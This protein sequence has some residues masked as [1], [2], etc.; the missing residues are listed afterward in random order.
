MPV[1]SKSKSHRRLRSSTRGRTALPR[2]GAGYNFSNAQSINLQ[3]LQ[4]QFV[5]VASAPK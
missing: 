4:A 2:F 5:I 1:R 3:Q